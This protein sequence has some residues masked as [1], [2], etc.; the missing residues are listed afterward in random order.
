MENETYLT[1]YFELQDGELF[2][3]QNVDSEDS[4][5]SDQIL[6]DRKTAIEMAQDI[7]RIMS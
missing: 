1:Q 2:C 3:I 4:E 6:L 5:P 7:L